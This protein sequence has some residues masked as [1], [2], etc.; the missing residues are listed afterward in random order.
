MAILRPSSD[1]VTGGWTSSPSGTL[2][3]CIDETTASDSDYIET[4]GTGNSSI[5]LLGSGS[6]PGN[7]NNHKLSY[8]AS[9]TSETLN[10]DVVQMVPSIVTSKQPWRRQPQVPVEVNWS[11]SITQKLH[12]GFSKNSFGNIAAIQTGLLSKTPSTEGM[13]YSNT[14][15]TNI[16]EFTGNASP[17]T[18]ELTVVMRLCSYGSQPD[19]GFGTALILPVISGGVQP[20][21]SY[22]VKNAGCRVRFNTS[23]SDDTANYWETN[24]SWVS[25]KWTTVVV[26]WASGEPA[27]IIKDNVSLSLSSS[28]GS[29]TGNIK[30]TDRLGVNLAA[31][32][33]NGAIAYAYIFGRKLTLSEIKS[34]TDNP[35]Q[36]FRPRKKVSYFDAPNVIATRTP[37]LTS[38]PADYSIDLTSGEA[39]TITDYTK[40]GLRF[41]T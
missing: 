14:T 7:D 22:F 26:R 30:S 10:V 20:P 23:T 28:A 37:S 25:N 9:S 18:S 16:A 33:F 31:L 5:I 11:N 39:A 24:E 6:D 19:S 40:L 35:F 29:K 21:F 2:A 36:I 38:S 12:C 15:S 3:S 32:R 27:D 41:R 34:I 8:R 4:T 13:V 17:Q 1:L